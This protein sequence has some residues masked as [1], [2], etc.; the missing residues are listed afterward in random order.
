[1]G[2]L[3]NGQQ[4]FSLLELYRPSYIYDASSDLVA[5]YLMAD[6]RLGKTLRVVYGV[7]LESFNQKL[8]S[9][10]D[11]NAPVRIDTTKLDILPSANIIYSMTSKQ[12][13]RVSYSRTLNRPEFREL[14]PFP[15]YDFVSRF[16]IEGDTNLT[17]A[18]IDNYDL[19]Y[20]FYPGRAQL[21]SA[22]GFY[23]SFTNP[24][25]LVTNPALGAQAKYQNARSAKVYGIELEVRS[26]L[27]TIFTSPE[28][29][30][31]SKLT[32]SANTSVLWSNVK[33]APIPGVVDPKAYISNRDL[34]GQSPYVVNSSLTY[35]NDDNNF[36]ATF[37]GNRVGDRIFIV[38]TVNDVDVYERARTVFDFQ[39][40]KSLKKEKW[41]VR[42]TARDILAQK[43][44]FYSDMN[45]D[46]KYSKTTDRIFSNYKP[47]STI[48]ASVTYKFN[49]AKAGTTKV[50][51]IN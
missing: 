32:F 14:A 11:N 50:P 10:T 47:G 5:G 17:R 8:N 31:L 12:N 15:F 44:L 40:A 25:E 51:F 45:S 41:E 30:I 35:A 19:R 7:R 37:S 3:K 21:F 42:V 20:E 13:L 29:S 33:I 28:S 9:N 43:L 23:K 27:G 49:R 46:G 1:M 38:G 24:I 18:S 4:G 48:S 6:Q 2:T 26:L 22:S 39:I 36:S 16:T 34:Q